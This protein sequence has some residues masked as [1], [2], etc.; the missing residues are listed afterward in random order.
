[1]ADFVIDTSGTLERRREPADDVLKAVCARWI[2]SARYRPEARP[3][4]LVASGQDGLLLQVRRERC[5]S[6]G[7]ARIAVYAAAEGTGTGSVHERAHERALPGGQPRDIE[8]SAP[9]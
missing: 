4:Y 2:D 5:G 9:S 6:E 1:M 3:R 8:P 7:A